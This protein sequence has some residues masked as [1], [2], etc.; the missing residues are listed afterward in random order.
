M[1]CLE[2]SDVSRYFAHSSPDPVKAGH[3]SM[4]EH[5][6]A[7]AALAQAHAVHFGA[8]QLAR[9]A[10]LLHDLGKYCKPFQRKLQG[11]ALQINHSTWGAKIALERYPQIGW[12]LAYGIAGHQA[13]LA[14][15]ASFDG[16]RPVG[17]AS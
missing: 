4:A 15:G 1:S 16:E 5:A 6:N 13:A 10:G 7:V 17:G 14:N 8:A 3:Q 2:S 12:L 9:A 11:Q